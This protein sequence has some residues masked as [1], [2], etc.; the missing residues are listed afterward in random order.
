MKN[1]DEYVQK[2]TSLL[3]DELEK[4]NVIKLVEKGKK[5]SEKRYQFADLEIKGATSKQISPGSIPNIIEDFYD[6]RNILSNVYRHIKVFNEGP[7]INPTLNLVFDKFIEVGVIDPRWKNEKIIRDLFDKAED[8]LTEDNSREK[9]IQSLKRNK[10]SFNPLIIKVLEYYSRLH[11]E[12]VFKE[13]HVTDPRLSGEKQITPTADFIVNVPEA[14]PFV[15]VEVKFRKKRVNLKEI[16][17]QGAALIRHYE[18]FQRRGVK[19]LVVL[20]TYANLNDAE[21]D[22]FSFKESVQ[23]RPTLR[24]KLFFLPLPFAYLENLNKHLRA[25]KDEILDRRIVNFTFRTQTPSPDKPT[26]DDHFYDKTIDLRKDNIEI[27]IKAKMSGH[28]RFGVRFS[29]QE[30]IPSRDERHPVKFPLV[31][32]QKETDSDRITGTY[33]NDLNVNKEFTTTVSK[34]ANEELIMKIYTEG[35]EKFVDIVDSSYKRIIES[36]ISV[37]SQN[38]CW[39]FGWA[40]NRNPFE[41]ETV[42]IEYSRNSP[43]IS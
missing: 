36:P 20:Y 42:I 32:L 40:D 27:R 30:D 34:Y 39:I 25:I 8:V 29:K 13:G 3:F 18:E 10:V 1:I 21:R 17:D 24:E 5:D 43:P 12:D 35:N 41:F 38:F 11:L 28:W 33:Y 16:M 14:V 22:A 4:S 19:C 31:H 23:R 6:F 7:G 37:G 15:I 26:I 2:C 9:A